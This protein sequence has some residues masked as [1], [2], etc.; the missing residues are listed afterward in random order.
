MTK[1]QIKELDKL[2]REAVFA[3]DKYKC[4]KCGRTDTLAPAHLYP[5]GRYRRLR[6]TPENILTLCWNCHLNWAHKNPIEFKE[7][8]DEELGKEAM[9]KLKLMSNYNDSSPMDYNAIKLYLKT[10]TDLREKYA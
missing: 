1:S 9:D 4:R 5:K 2:L 10:L 7:W 8:L 3:R 6:W